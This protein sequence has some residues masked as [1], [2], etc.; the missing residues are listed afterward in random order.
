MATV[1]EQLRRAREARN[2][3]VEQVAEITKIR[4][5]HVKALEEGNYDVFSAPVY[6][7]G[8][9]RTY[10]TLLK[11][12]VPATMA[13]LEAEL[14]QTNRF[15]EAPA[16]TGE[17][18]GLVDF[19]MLQLSK[20]DWRKGVWAAGMLVVLIIAIVSYFSWKHFRTRDPLRNVKPGIYQPAQTNRGPTLPL[21]TNA[22]R[23]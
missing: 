5:D 17:P 12:D 21:P 7:K 23:R 2:L 6:I 22:P 14:G 18:K 10:S 13:A 3:T 15:A 8:F 4:T 11:E 19:A 20:L 9:V 1:G 16:L